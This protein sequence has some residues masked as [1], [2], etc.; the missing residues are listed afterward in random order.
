MK[1]P[2]PIPVPNRFRV[3]LEN[4]GPSVTQQHFKEECDINRI[5]KRFADTGILDHV[6]AA[7]PAYGYASSQ[8][9]TEAMQIV[10][11]AQ[12]EFEQLP[13]KIRAHFKNDPV[14]F[15]D[16]MQDPE[17]RPELEKLGLIAPLEIE[18]PEPAPPPDDPAQPI[19]QPPEPKKEPE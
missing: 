18:T 14:L 17:S 13:S 7:T 15:L 16:A 4:T 5:V 2:D 6:Q 3:L 12:Q 9:F 8:S 11:K 10:A 19:S 1:R